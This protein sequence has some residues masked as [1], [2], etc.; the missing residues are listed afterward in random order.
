MRSKN[1]LKEK[2]NFKLLDPLQAVHEAASSL[3]EAGIIDG[4]TMHDFDALCIPPIHNLSPNQIKQVRLKEKVSQAVFA[5]YLN[6]SI[7]TIKQWELGDKHPRG[8]S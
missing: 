5:K 1:T 3:Y 8:T 2:E 4:K 6:T 7:S